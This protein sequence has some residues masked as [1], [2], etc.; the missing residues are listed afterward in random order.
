MTTTGKLFLIERKEVGE[1]CWEEGVSRSSVLDKNSGKPEHQG[2]SHMREMK[3][4]RLRA[5]TK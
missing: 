5:K 2:I 1:E 4:G 3:E